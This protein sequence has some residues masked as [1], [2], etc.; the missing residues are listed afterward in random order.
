MKSKEEAPW[1][2]KISKEELAA[3]PVAEF[4]GAVKVI[5]SEEDVAN[6]VE[7][8]RQENV[9]GFDTETKPSFK[10]GQSNNVALLQLST[11]S[12]CF[13]FRLNRIGLPDNL[14]SLLE[15]SQIMKIGLSIHDDFHNLNK[16]Y[17][18]QPEGFIDLQSFVKD[19]K[20]ADNSLA[21][22]FAILFG[23]RISKG[24]R[25][26]NWEAQTLTEHQQTY[27]AL[28]AVACLDIY[29][30]LVDGK[31]NPENSPFRCPIELP[32]EPQL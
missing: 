28:D 30:F 1:H 9:L 27:A 10:K 23:K 2:V 8:L 14:K 13:L 31:F 26:T 5:D 22:I 29:N 11:S 17:S 19:Y 4:S 20:I 7:T 21:K 12:L 15:D 3:L 24:Q 18:L 16:N 32:E 6:A 25:L